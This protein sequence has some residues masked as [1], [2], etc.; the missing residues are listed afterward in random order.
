VFKRHKKDFSFES[1]SLSVEEKK[2]ENCFRRFCQKLYG[3]MKHKHD[4]NK[5]SH[6]AN[7]DINSNVLGNP[8]GLKVGI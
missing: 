4:N 3:N 7:P 8:K 1:S 6:E 2:R 5:D